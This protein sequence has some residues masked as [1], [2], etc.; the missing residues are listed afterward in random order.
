[1]V[2]DRAVYHFRG[3]RITSPIC[4]VLEKSYLFSIIPATLNFDRYICIHFQSSQFLKALNCFCSGQVGQITVE[5][6]YR[7]ASARPMEE[8]RLQVTTEGI[9]AYFEEPSAVV[10]GMLPN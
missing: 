8:A 6:N 7:T 10:D 1:M 5:T 4:D 2:R 9:V 3:L